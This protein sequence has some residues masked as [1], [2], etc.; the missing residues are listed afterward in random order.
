MAGCRATGSQETASGPTALN[1][2]EEDVLDG[3][4]PA[5]APRTKIFSYTN[6]ALDNAIDAH[7]RYAA[8]VVHE[9]NLEPESALDDYYNAALL[10]PTN[11]PLILDVSQQLLQAKRPEKALELLSHASTNANASGSLFAEMGFIYSK[12]GKTNEAVAADRVAIRKD[13][14]SIAGYQ[15]LFLDYMQDKQ[16]ARVMALLEEAGKVKGTDAAFLVNL[17]DMYL[18]VGVDAPERK[19]AANQ[20]ALAAL[21]RAAKMKITEVRVQLRLADGFNLLGETDEAARIYQDAA[22]QIPDTAPQF[23]SVHAKLADI[24]LHQHN[25]KRAEQEL[26]VILRNNPTDAQTYYLLGGLAYEDTNYSKAAEYFR[27]TILFSPD[28]EPAYYELATAQLGAEKTDDALETLDRARRRFPQNFSD[29]YLTGVAYSRLKNYTNAL[30]HFTTAEI[31]AKNGE[32]KRLTGAF[33]F[34]LGATCERVGDYERAEKYFQKCLELAPDSAETLNYLGYMWAEHDQ[35]LDQAR[36]MIAKAV[37]A[38]PKNAAYLDSMAWV[39]FKLHQPKPALDYALKA[40]QF[41]EE[42]DATVYDH[43]GDIYAA[44]G[45]KDKAQ[46]AWKKSLSLEASDVVRKKMESTVK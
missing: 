23:D 42:E 12:L 14:R 44:L 5:P 29:E 19:D 8:G 22:K 46:Q 33:Y 45:Q 20:H 3:S 36:D 35:K 6:A 40:I 21:Q 9:L 38:E 31:V 30:D 17:A 11:E 2:V 32:P 4:G 15:S 27:N 10:D 18:Q 34:E 37:K 16:V 25:A 39:L 1:T 41:S 28:F 13:P 26:E 43:L 24:Y 7:A